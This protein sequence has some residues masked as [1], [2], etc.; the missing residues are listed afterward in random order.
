MTLIT[1]TV[2]LLPPGASPGGA[3]LDKRAYRNTCGCAHISVTG[4]GTMTFVSPSS[5]PGYSAAVAAGV[6]P[7]PGT[8]HGTPDVNNTLTSR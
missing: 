1:I 6:G 4:S 2:A 3:S 7:S 8:G 5:G